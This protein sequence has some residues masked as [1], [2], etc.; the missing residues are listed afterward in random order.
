MIRRSAAPGLASVLILSACTGTASGEAR[1]APSPTE[2]DSTRAAAILK[3]V[4]ETREL[5][6]GGSGAL[7]T[8]IGN[9][10]AGTPVNVLS[11]SFAFVCTGG[12]R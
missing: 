9:T 5:L 7:E 1:P 12:G 8:A 10:L 6:G 3:P 4:T 11:V 2:R